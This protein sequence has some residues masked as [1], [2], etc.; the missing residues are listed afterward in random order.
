[1]KPIEF[2]HNKSQTIYQD[3]MNRVKKAIKPLRKEDRED[4]LMEINSNIYEYINEHPTEN[5]IDSL[6]E[7]LERLGKPEV[8]LSSVIADKKMKQAVRSFNPIHV[9]KALALN[10]SNG[11]SYI[12]FIVLYL[13][14][15][16]F[17]ILAVAKIIFPENTGFFTDGD[18]YLFGLMAT[19]SIEN[20]R[21]LLGGWFIPVVLIIS[22]II[23]LIIT[24]LLKLKYKLK[25]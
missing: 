20:S 1:M 21:E 17:L 16:C 10:V 24:L 6:K 13:F 9:I 18:S 19:D 11:I 5:E 25:K 23:Y 4:I 8:M 14:L 3:Y 7:I 15:F 12:L 2:A 22:V